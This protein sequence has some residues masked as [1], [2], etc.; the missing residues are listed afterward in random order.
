MSYC[1]TLLIILRAWW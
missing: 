1:M